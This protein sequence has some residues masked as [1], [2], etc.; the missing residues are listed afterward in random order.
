[1]AQELGSDA[2][3]V[4]SQVQAFTAIAACHLLPSTDSGFPQGK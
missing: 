3:W 2:S 1:M 4:H